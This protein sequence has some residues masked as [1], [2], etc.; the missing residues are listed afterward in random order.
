MLKQS[1]TGSN[2]EQGYNISIL[3]NSNRKELTVHPTLTHSSHCALRYRWTLPSVKGS[4]QQIWVPC[5][6]RRQSHRSHFFN[7]TFRCCRSPFCDR[8]LRW[9][10]NKCVF[11]WH[12]TYSYNYLTASYV[13]AILHHIK[14]V[15]IILSCLDIR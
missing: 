14:F 2:D 4:V 3:F 1:N 7:P 6:L 12:A 15:M 11:F 13:T 8:F 10:M 9:S 5:V